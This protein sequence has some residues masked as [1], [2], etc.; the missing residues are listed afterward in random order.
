LPD[1][2]FAMSSLKF[3][4]RP[5]THAHASTLAMSV[6]QDV[7]ASGGGQ[8]SSSEGAN[9]RSDDIA[10]EFLDDQSVNKYDGELG[11]P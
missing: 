8:R 10:L 5:R 1:A 6:N 3:T 9:A 7:S 2:R 4:N 11:R